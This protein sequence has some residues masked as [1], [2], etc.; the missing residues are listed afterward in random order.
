M[1]LS[2]QATVE[3]PET[4]LRQLETLARSEGKTVADL[5]QQIVQ[6][7]MADRQTLN[8]LR[9]AASPPVIP[10]TETGPIQPVSGRDVDELLS[11]DHLPA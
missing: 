2:M 3:L 4:V 1:T 9:S 5:I 7:H 11:R 6:S 10:A 8:D